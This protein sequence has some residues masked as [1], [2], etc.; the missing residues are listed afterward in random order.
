MLVLSRKLGE[1]VRIGG[2]IT[3]T[4]L[5]ADRGR[6]RLGIEAPQDVLVLREELAEWQAPD[7]ERPLGSLPGSAL[8][9]RDKE[10]EQ[11]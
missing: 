9:Q 3:I 10:R 7:G 1:K 2:G 5:G 6:A 4:V 11:S 8:V